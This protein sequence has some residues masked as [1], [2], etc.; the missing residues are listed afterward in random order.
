MIGKFL[1]GKRAERNRERDSGK[2]WNVS[3]DMNAFKFQYKNKNA[4]RIQCDRK[5]LSLFEWT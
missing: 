2:I 4:A 5:S 3:K 1:K